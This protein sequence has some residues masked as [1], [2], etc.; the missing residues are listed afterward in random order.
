MTINSASELTVRMA[1]GSREIE[2][3]QGEAWFDVAKDASRP[4]IVTA[5]KV[6]ARAVGTAFSVRRRETGVEVLVTEGVVESWSEEDVSLRLK[7]EAGNAPCSVIRRWSIMKAIAHR[8]WT[9][10]WHGA[11]G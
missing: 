10:R 7:L 1:K 9:V 6:R 5:G 3:A 4:F 8:R 11:A 2:I